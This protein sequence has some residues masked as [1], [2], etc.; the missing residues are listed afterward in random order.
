MNSRGQDVYRARYPEMEPV[1]KPPPLATVNGIGFGVYG[2]RD[3]GTKDGTYVKTYGFTTDSPYMFRLVAFHGPWDGTRQLS[4]ADRAGFN[5]PRSHLG[6]PASLILCAF[7]N[8]LST[9]QKSA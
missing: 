6:L 9:C 2:S 4:P 5:W 3:V 8:L 1:S 7:L